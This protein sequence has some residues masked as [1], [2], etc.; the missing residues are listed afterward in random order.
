MS[1]CSF[2][3]D[4]AEAWCEGEAEEV[5]GW[6][7]WLEGHGG[8]R[9]MEVSVCLQGVWMLVFG[10]V[11]GVWV[12]GLEWWWRRGR[13]GWWGRRGRV[14]IGERLFSA[15]KMMMPPV[16]SIVGV[17]LLVLVGRGV[18][19]VF[20]MLCGGLLGWLSGVVGVVRGLRSGGGEGGGGRWGGVGRVLGRVLG[21]ERVERMG[22]VGGLGSWGEWGVVGGGCAVLGVCGLWMASC[23][24]SGGGGR[25]GDVAGA[26]RG[27]V[28]ERGE[29][30]GLDGR[31]RVRS[32]D[33]TVPFER[34]M[35]LDVD[36]EPML[37]VRIVSGASE[38]VLGVGGSADGGGER[39]A[40]V[41]GDWP[42]G[43]DLVRRRGGGSS[44]SSSSSA[45]SASRGSGGVGGGVGVEVL[46]GP[47]RIR[48]EGGDGGGVGV[49]GRSG[50]W[51]VTGAAAG[52]S[53]GAGGGGGKRFV[54]VGGVGLRVRVAGVLDSG[55]GV[56]DVDGVP[57]VGEL[58]LLPAS[59]A[60]N[61][62][63]SGA[64]GLS[65]EVIE[66]IGVERYVPGV[67]VKELFSS[68][69]LETFRVQAV[70]AR[71]YALHERL[72]ARAAGER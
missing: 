40:L 33:P 21:R 1:D 55:G 22:G 70:A 15:M 7:A 18:V 14:V 10:V 47:L 48:R 16:L 72:R 58:Q 3:E 45:S 19:V 35:G 71:T 52:S 36:Q 69:P 17:V 9:V 67:L 38:V 51:V 11:F 43:G 60:V 8:D 29:G 20:L 46:Q 49:G 4:R 66:L 39:L 62:G 5:V 41:V 23:R 25:G 28:E 68:W 54:D 24:S 64:D 26:G 57:Y 59:G 30:V 65:F 50:V 53:G 42:A 27:G 2:D 12:G 63:S 6:C 56:I 44:S 34:L 31:R 37:R 61:G 13:G 32:A